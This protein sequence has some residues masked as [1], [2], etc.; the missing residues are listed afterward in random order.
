M[1]KLFSY[2]ILAVLLLLST[3]AE[4]QSKVKAQY[5]EETEL[6]SIVAHLAEVSGYDWD[7]EDVGVDD[8]LAEVDSYSV[9]VLHGSIPALTIPSARH[10]PSS[11]FLKSVPVSRSDV[12]K[13]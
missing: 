5:L 4:A 6:V 1:N 12:S 9:G 7:V 2:T 8:Y 13:A 3:H 10:Q 11:K